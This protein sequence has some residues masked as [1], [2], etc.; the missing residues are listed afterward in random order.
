MWKTF[1]QEFKISLLIMFL[2]ETLMPLGLVLDQGLY[3]LVP[4]SG[5]ECYVY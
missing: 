2:E 1:L 4:I 5:I 3:D